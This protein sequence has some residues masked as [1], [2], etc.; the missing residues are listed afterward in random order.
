MLGDLRKRVGD[1]DVKGSATTPTGSDRRAWA[2]VLST[3]I[4]IQQGG[5]VSPRARAA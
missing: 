4:D 2:R 1:D 5:T 3:D